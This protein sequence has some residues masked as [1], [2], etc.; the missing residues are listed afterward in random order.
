MSDLFSFSFKIFLDFFNL[1]GFI[2]IGLKF[3]IG[4]QNVMFSF[5]KLISFSCFKVCGKFIVFEE[6]KKIW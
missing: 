4:S 3:S 1:S 6:M 5:S 2:T